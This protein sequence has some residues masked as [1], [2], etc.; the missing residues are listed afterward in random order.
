MM[1]KGEIQIYSFLANTVA[2]Q[3]AK[4]SRRNTWMS[5]QITF[6]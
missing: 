2:F 5:A 4:F 1:A 6:L 3:H